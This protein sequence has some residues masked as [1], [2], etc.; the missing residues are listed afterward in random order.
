MKLTTKHQTIH[1]FQ[2]YIYINNMLKY[3]EKFPKNIYRSITEVSHFLDDQR[4][5]SLSC[6]D[7]FTITVDTQRIK[8]KNYCERMMLSDPLCYGRKAE[9]IMWRKTYHDVYSTAKI[10]RKVSAL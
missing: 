8:L 5:R 9:D 1:L 7:L 10:L 4:G 6:K 2:K 3:K